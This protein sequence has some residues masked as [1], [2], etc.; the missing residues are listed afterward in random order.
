MNCNINNN[1]IKN[2][3][4]SLNKLYICEVAVFGAPVLHVGRKV[5]RKHAVE[6]GTTFNF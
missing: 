4:K 2:I 1:K 6:K 5:F 3:N